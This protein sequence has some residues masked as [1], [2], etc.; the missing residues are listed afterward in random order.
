MEGITND[1]AFVNAVVVDS[2]VFD[3]WDSFGGFAAPERYT[4]IG[5]LASIRFGPMSKFFAGTHGM[6]GQSGHSVEEKKEGSR[7]AMRNITTE[8][9]NINQE[10]GIENQPRDLWN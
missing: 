8:R 2:T 1:T 5:K 10:F 4:Y 3:T 6:G 7:K 9:V